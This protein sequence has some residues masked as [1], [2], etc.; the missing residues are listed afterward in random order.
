MV[1]QSSTQITEQE[2]EL[3]DRQ[4]RLWGLD[5]QKRLRSSR[6]CVVGMGGLGCEVAKNLVLSGVKELRMVD[7][8][9]LTKE[10][11]TSQFLAPRDQVGNNRAQASLQRVQ[12]LNPMVEVTAD[13]ASSEEKDA[14]FFQK[15]DVVVAT[16]CGQA[17]LVRINSICRAANILFY[18]GDVFGFFGFSFMDLVSHSF[19]EEVTQQVQSG[20]GPGEKEGEPA[21]KKPKIVE[22]ETKSVKKE[23]AFVS[24]AETL[25]VDW[26]SELYAKR[27][28]RMD[29]SFFL[30]QVLFAFKTET[31]HSPRPSARAED[32]AKLTEL[33]DSTLTKLAVPTTKIPD[34]MLG[35]LFAELSPV[36]AI[37][38]GVLA[39]EVIKAIS[40]RDAPHNNFFFYNPLESCGVVETIGY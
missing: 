37:V 6:V 32:L 26:S 12:Q 33:R 22:P 29:P 13:P 7:S 24:L 10:D 9:N 3:Y 38:G 31:G 16:T 17:E 14:E 15:F 8:N 27:I 2:A 21:A 36:A 4:I 1:E 5:A 19:V 18:A 39:Q 11:A 28:R 23:M 25:K 35:L 20:S 34:Q 30:L 40:N